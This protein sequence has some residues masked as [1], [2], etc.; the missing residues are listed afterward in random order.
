MRDLNLALPLVEQ[1]EAA[2]DV[3]DKKE[4]ERSV[5]SEVHWVARTYQTRGNLMEQQ[6]RSTWNT[7]L[8]GITMNMMRGG[9]NMMEWHRPWRV[10]S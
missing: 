4:P 7:G 5:G 6:A 1:A 9:M 10:A 8:P 2:L 3:L